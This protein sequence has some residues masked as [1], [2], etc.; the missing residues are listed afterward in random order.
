MQ[1]HVPHGDAHIGIFYTQVMPWSLSVQSQIE[2]ITG[3][4]IYKYSTN[5]MNL[6]ARKEVFILENIK[7]V[8][9]ITVAHS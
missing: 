9:K 4:N 8:Y 6:T 7:T 1:I 2:L 3:L 5:E